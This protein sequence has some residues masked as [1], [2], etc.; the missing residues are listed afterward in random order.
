MCKIYILNHS[1]ESPMQ[2]LCV[3]WP[4]ALFFISKSKAHRYSVHIHNWWSFCFVKY[5]QHTYVNTETREKPPEQVT[6]LPSISTLGSLPQTISSHI[7][8][9][10]DKT[11]IQFRNANIFQR[12]FI[13]ILSFFRPV[14]YFTVQNNL[15]KH[16][17]AYVGYCSVFFIYFFF[18]YNIA[19]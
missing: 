5:L 16:T 4:L 1:C 2:S 11:L 12:V 19:I 7:S 15:Y 17:H 13:I 14:S 6:K 18:K 9:L 8:S 10:C 3:I